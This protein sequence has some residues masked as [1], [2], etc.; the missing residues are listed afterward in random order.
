MLRGKSAQLKFD[1][2]SKKGDCTKFQDGAYGTTVNAV[3]TCSGKNIAYQTGSFY[4]YC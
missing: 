4:I 1:A 2:N 3:K